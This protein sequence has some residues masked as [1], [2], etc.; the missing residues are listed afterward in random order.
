MSI[1]V[2]LN[3]SDANGA[4]FAWSLSPGVPVLSDGWRW[5]QLKLVS[6]AAAQGPSL[7]R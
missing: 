6:A 1:P 5:E 7:S 2:H 4:I 3:P